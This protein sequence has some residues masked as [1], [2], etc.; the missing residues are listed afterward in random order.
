[1]TKLI[2]LLILI[3]FGVFVALMA[4]RSMIVWPLMAPIFLLLV[5]YYI[6]SSLVT[7]KMLEKGRGEKDFFSIRCSLVSKDGTAITPG[8]MTVTANEIVFYS[9]KSWKGGIKPIWSC[10]SQELEG[11]TIKRVDDRHAGI[12]LSLAGANAEVK[13]ASSSI[14]K[15]EKA[16]RNALAWPEE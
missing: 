4:F 16:F 6:T 3:L 12:V 8:A 5:L 10:F 9:R 13:I 14:Q 2:L 15:K 1:M 7:R 11:Y